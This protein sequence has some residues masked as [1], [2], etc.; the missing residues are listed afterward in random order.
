MNTHLLSTA[1]SLIPNTCKDVSFFP[2]TESKEAN[3]R[4][5][6]SLW[7]QFKGKS[8]LFCTF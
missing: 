3:L 6:D 7:E 2:H 8:I 5:G 1:S 4:Q